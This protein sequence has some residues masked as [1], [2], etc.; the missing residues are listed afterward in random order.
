[1]DVIGDYQRDGYAKIAGLLAPEVAARVLATMHEALNRKPI[2]LSTRTEHATLLQRPAFEI[3]GRLYQPMLFLLYGLT[4]AISRLAGCDLL[5]AYDF[6]RVY[7]QGDIC[8]VHTDRPSCEH[9][10]SLTLGSSDDI[11]WPLE[12]ETRPSGGRAC[13][14]DD[15]GD[16]AYASLPMV[17]GDA[18]LYRGV[19]HRHGRLT[20]NPNAWS[21]HLFLHWVDRHGPYRDHAFD[22]C[23]VPAKV[24]FVFA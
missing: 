18:V 3:Y 17:A 10:V 12:L 13:M 22:K 14:A 15:F 16:A 5:P 20:P 8:R 6:F 4:P 7:R 9:S 21:A 1:M 19:E 11:S 23:E 24:D 2:P